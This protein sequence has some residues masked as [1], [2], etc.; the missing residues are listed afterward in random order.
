MR[1]RLDSWAGL[2]LKRP[3]LPLT[4]PRNADGI[5]CR[6]KQLS[7]LCH[8]AGDQGT[9]SPAASLR[10]PVTRYPLACPTWLPVC[11]HSLLIIL[12]CQPG[13]CPHPLLVP[14]HGW[15]GCL[16]ASIS[17]DH[18]LGWPYCLPASIL[19][20]SF[21]PLACLF[22]NI[23]SMLFLVPGWTVCLLASIACSPFVLMGPA[24]CLLISCS[25]SW[26]ASAPVCHHS[27]R[28]LLL[29]WPR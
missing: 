29:G 19:M 24:A 21:S 14:E 17:A 28:I 12:P 8:V 1:A 2:V 7:R 22:V 5:S 9:A 4:A 25:L 26:L 16:R 23:H 20:F 6:H 10:L 18:F 27:S 15:T 11:F 13:A 3:V